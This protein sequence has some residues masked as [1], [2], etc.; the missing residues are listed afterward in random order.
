MT[1]VMEDD[2]NKFHVLCE[3]VLNTIAFVHES[4]KEFLEVKDTLLQHHLPPSVLLSLSI[5]SSKLFRSITDM[6]EPVNELIRLVRIFSTPWE[7]KSAALKKILDDFHKK[8]RQLDVALKRLTLVDAMSKKIA[9]ERRLL[10]WEKLYCKVT[11]SKGHGRRWK[12]IIK[13][14]KERTKLGYDVLVH[15]VDQVEQDV[16]EPFPDK[17][18][19]TESV[20]PQMDPIAEEGEEGSHME[21][22]SAGEHF[23]DGTDSEASFGPETLQ[24]GFSMAGQGMVMTTE[25]PKPEVS[26]TTTETHPPEYDVIFFVRCYCP[27]GVD[28]RNIKC[29]ITHGTQ[30]EKTSR[31][32]FTDEEIAKQVAN[33]PP[34]KP[35]GPKRKGAPPP[36]PE[37]ILPK[38]VKYSELRFKL[39]V[40][41][42]KNRE[43]PPTLE[44]LTVTVHVGED[45][46]VVAMGTV[47]AEDI[48][49]CEMP[50]IYE[51]PKGTDGEYDLSL[52]DSMMYTS[53]AIVDAELQLAEPLPVAF[54]IYPLGGGRA[55]SELQA[56]GTVPLF[57]Y[58]RKIY[59]PRLLNRATGTMNL[60]DLILEEIG[61]DI[62]HQTKAT[63]FPEKHD[64]TNS[65]MTV[66]GTPTLSRHSNEEETIPAEELEAILDSH[67][68]DME[69]MQISYERRISAMEEEIDRLHM[70]LESQAALGDQAPPRSGH[71]ASQTSKESKHKVF[72]Y[73]KEKREMKK[74]PKNQ[75]LPKWGESLPADFF[76][77]L[78]LF[79]EESEA[80]RRAIAVHMKREESESIE[81]KL[82]FQNKAFRGHQNDVVDAL[83]DVSLPSLYNP[84]TGNNVYNPRVSQYFHPTGTTGL[85]LTQPPSM[86][87]L[88]PLKNK[89]SVINLFD[90]GQSI[91]NPNQ[92]LQR[93]MTARNGKEGTFRNDAPANTADP[94]KRNRHDVEAMR[95][96]N[97][98]MSAGERLQTTST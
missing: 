70:S 90:L 67:Q 77:R 44:A 71:T 10:N 13:E 25:P 84:N 18:L 66:R 17:E 6:H 38:H 30:Y 20:A 92:L 79:Q 39:P 45:E 29:S 75:K 7:E 96:D 4:L 9:Y 41:Y 93:Y 91:H 94:S 80:N 14:L 72:E 97:L 50:E 21:E 24:S 65:P 35:K 3:G 33:D 16:N 60:R 37:P 22:E 74:I 1:G 59:K 31:L 56:V 19:R 76:E 88:P 58:Y 63:L 32:D 62:R 46:E 53:Q 95:S 87:S 69:L 11:S 89:M 28:G 26:D 64:R 36:P 78:E 43:I 57:F 82:A 49:G 54:P 85:R 68:R 48:V 8:K 12:Y 47:E 61:V 27:K 5:T 55:G 81:K 98:P 15:H 34:P 52:Q 51:L 23:S 83:K 42:I 40:K 73:K 86:M 2:P